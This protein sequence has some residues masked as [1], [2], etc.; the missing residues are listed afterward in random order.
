M[1]SYKI[2]LSE[3]LHPKLLEE[4]YLYEGLIWTHPIEPTVHHLNEIINGIDNIIFKQ[5]PN[6]NRF[7]IFIKDGKISEKVLKW[8]L[9]STNNRGWC[10][11]YFV[12]RPENINYQSPEQ[13]IGMVNR[14]V[15]IKLVFDAKFDIEYGKDD[16]PDYVLY[17]ATPMKYK[18]KILKIGLAPKSKSKAATHS[19]RVYFT[20]D[21]NGINKLLQNPKFY[22]DETEF[23]IFKID[24]WTLF[25][26]RKIRFFEDPAYIGQAVYTYENIPPKFITIEKEIR[27]MNERITK[28]I[29]L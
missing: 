8:I 17:H 2:S 23:V 13:F 16:F 24:L 18:E 15:N 11:S 1:K 26:S 28:N 27:A 7:Y 6:E 3:L 9:T 12:E 29:K 14:N 4:Q 25:K 21:M 10:P 5:F 20:F 19:H 22:P